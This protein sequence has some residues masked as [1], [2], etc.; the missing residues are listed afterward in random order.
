MAFAAG[1]TLKVIGE[2]AFA[3]CSSLRNISLPDGLVAIR[4]YA[5]SGSGL[6]EIALPGTVREVGQDAFREC[7]NLR[8]VHVGEDWDASLSDASVPASARVGPPPETLVCGA[9]VWDLRKQKDIV[10]P[11]G[12]EKVGSRWFWGCEAE[13]VTMPASVREIGT[14]AFHGCKNLRRIFFQGD[15]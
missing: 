1:S 8:A 13:S 7:D 5:F 3:G 10:I 9:R 4:S 15:S 6:E 14:D 12:V 2:E 11:D